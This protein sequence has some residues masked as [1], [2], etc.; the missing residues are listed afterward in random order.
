MTNERESAT[1][2]RS[3]TKVIQLRFEELFS[4]E[5]WRMVSPQAEYDTAVCGAIECQRQPDGNWKLWFRMSGADVP[6]TSEIVEESGPLVDARQ[7]IA[8]FLRCGVDY[9]SNPDLE[10][11]ES[12]LPE[13]AEEDPSLAAGLRDVLQEE[14]A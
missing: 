9:G 14:E 6:G 4:A 3:G 5:E 1:A 11:L 8:A 12:L 13:L 10:E 2:H 7:F